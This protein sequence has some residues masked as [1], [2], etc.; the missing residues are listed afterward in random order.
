MGYLLGQK[1]NIDWKISSVTILSTILL[2]ID[3]YYAFTAFKYLDRFLLYLIIP[4]IVILVIFREKPKEY[5]MSFGNW[6]LGLIYTAIG[7]LVLAPALY[8]L[9]KGNLAMKI[10]YEGLVPGLPWTTFLDL[11]GW[12]FFFRGWILF[13]YLRKFGH[14]AL[15]LQAVPFAL[16]HINK[17]GIETFSTIFG[18]FAFGWVAYRTESFVWPF[19]IHWFISTFVILVAS[20]AV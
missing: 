15:W 14:D 1:L 6:K 5:G 11:V 9:V 2:I 20:G 18:G 8:F 12:E 17:P 4:L 3:H 13:A 7:I 10:Y 19:L 16:A